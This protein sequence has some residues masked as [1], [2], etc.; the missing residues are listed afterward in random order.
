MEKETGKQR[1]ILEITNVEMMRFNNFK[2][3][4]NLISD[5]ASQLNLYKYAH[6]AG[7]ILLSSWV[8]IGTTNTSNDPDVPAVSEQYRALSKQNSTWC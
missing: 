7:Y 5:Y 8:A 1:P 2:L 6:C 3:Y 4:D